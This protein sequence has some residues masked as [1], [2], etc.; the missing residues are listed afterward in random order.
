[1]AIFS[2]SLSSP[3]PKSHNRSFFASITK[4]LWHHGLGHPGVDVL[5]SLRYSL[6]FPSSKHLSSICQSCVL[7]K[8]IK[9]PFSS[10]T[11]ITH[12]PFDITQ[13][14]LWTS[15]TPSSSGHRY[16]ILF[17][18]DKKTSCGHILLPKSPTSFLFSFNFSMM[19]TQFH[20]NIKT[21]QCDNG[22]EFNNQ[23]F[24]NFCSQ[25]GI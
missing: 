7:G 13:T 15:P 25:N 22:Q 5:S 3:P 21:I 17:L 4:Y 18:D 2:P 9:L 23:N 11:S 19:K 20:H 24:Q 6:H 16:Y 10:S 8:Q 1:M 14:D 12:L